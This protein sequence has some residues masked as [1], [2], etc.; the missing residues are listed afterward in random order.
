MKIWPFAI[1]TKNSF[2][3]LFLDRLL[4]SFFQIVLVML[5][6]AGARVLGV[7]RSLDDAAMNKCCN[8]SRIS[9]NYIETIYLGKVSNKPQ[10]AILNASNSL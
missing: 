10:L 9:Y 2:V 1:I 7:G 3:K 8:T 4:E 5:W 6:Q